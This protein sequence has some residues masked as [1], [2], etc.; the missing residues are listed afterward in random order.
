[1]FLFILT[2][3]DGMMVEFTHDKGTVTI[4]M[5]KLMDNKILTIIRSNVF[6]YL[7]LC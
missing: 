4:Q 7:D 1:M 6:V 5:L 2:Y 3:A